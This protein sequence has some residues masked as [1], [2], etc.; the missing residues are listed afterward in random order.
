ME[1]PKGADDANSLFLEDPSDL[2][3]SARAACLIEYRSAR[4]QPEPSQNEPNP[5]E[6]FF[7]VP[8]NV[9]HPEW[10]PTLESPTAENP[11]GPVLVCHEGETTRALCRY[12][13]CLSF[14]SLIR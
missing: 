1:F 14:L 9:L 6:S 10:A 12:R 4:H 8:H 13:T 2:S 11:G 7:V 3:A 5:R